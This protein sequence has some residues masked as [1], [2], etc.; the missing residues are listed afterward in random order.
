MFIHICLA[1]CRFQT[2]STAQQPPQPITTAYTRLPHPTRPCAMPCPLQIYGQSL[3]EP[4]SD[5]RRVLVVTFRYSFVQ[6]FDHPLRL[7]RTPPICSKIICWKDT[8]ASR[9]LRSVASF[10][11]FSTAY[12]SAAPR[13]SAAALRRCTAACGQMMP[14]SNTT[15]AKLPRTRPPVRI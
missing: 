6:C 15:R 13:D 3:P 2:D 10:P 4:P 1:C 14:T 7:R 9:H 5:K 11:H 8:P 12:C